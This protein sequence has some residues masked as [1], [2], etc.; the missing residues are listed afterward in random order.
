MLEAL[1]DR[2]ELGEACADA[3]VVVGLGELGWSFTDEQHECAVGDFSCLRER[4]TVAPAGCSVVTP[5][6]PR[7]LRTSGPARNQAPVANEIITTE[8][9][10]KA[11]SRPPHE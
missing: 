2:F 3:V 1:S 11:S 10:V 5:T 9:V 7:R 8:Q 4:Q 6:C